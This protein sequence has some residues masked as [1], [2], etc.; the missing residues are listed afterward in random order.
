[1][2]ETFP[3][4]CIEWSTLEAAIKKI[5]EAKKAAADGGDGTAMEEDKDAE[6]LREWERELL[7]KC[8]EV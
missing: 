5:D 7:S 6:G 3:G 8:K 1:M 2:L 4:G